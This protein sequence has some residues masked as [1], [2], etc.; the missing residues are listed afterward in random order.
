MKIGVIGGGSSYTPEL[1]EGLL[2][3]RDLL[4]LREICLMDIN[5]ERLE[6]LGAL[7][8][9]MARKVGADVEIRTTTDTR[10]AVEG[11]SFVL[12]QFRAGG[13]Q[14]R[15]RDEKLGLRHGIIGQETTGIGGFAKALRTIPIVLNVAH[16]MEE[17]CPEAW[18]LNFT[19][20]AGII[21]E[22]AMK[23]S[24]AKAIGLCN[25]PIGYIMDASKATGA[26][27]E[28][29]ELDYVG[30]NH[31][32]WVR[33]CKIEGVDRMPEL[34]EAAAKEFEEDGDTPG[35]LMAEWTR[36]YGVVPNYYLQ[37]Y[38]CRDRM[39]EKLRGKEKTRGEE[40]ME[41]EKTL[42]EKYKDPNL[43]EKPKELEKRGGAF[44]S[45]AA[46]NLIESLH[47]DK[48][49]VQIVN[50][51]NNGVVPELPDGV[52]VEVPCKITSA[53]PVPLPQ[54]PLEPEIRGILQVVKS[55]EELT[56][57]AGARGDRR[58][59]ILALSVH[60]LVR[61]IEHLETLL[62]EVIAEN[63]EFL[64]QFAPASATS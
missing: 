48:G 2:D 25:I 3:R 38:Y 27:P 57:E 21:S 19:N 45:T 24:K 13:M 43:E 8:Q 40:V 9:R 34:L 62:D 46:V 37:Y 44:Y 39:L 64:P 36:F 16:L 5:A 49:D 14:A 52:S 11:C 47:T 18:L 58:A 56:V 15:V 26:A 41:V 59:A 1:L 6:I 7:G 55:Y 29:V 42:F 12:T 61:Q 31:L 22:A 20:P 32:S 23:H 30:I 63:A 10:E 54:R 28:K 51:P 4:G 60:P 33:G 35:Q 53:G 17:L 50:V